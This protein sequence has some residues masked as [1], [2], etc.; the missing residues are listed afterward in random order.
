M[1]VVS[2]CWLSMPSPDL[3]YFAS[4]SASDTPAASTP[5]A[6]RPASPARREA[7]SFFWSFSAVAPSIFLR[8]DVGSGGRASRCRHGKPS[9]S[10]LGDR[11]Q[12]GSH[13]HA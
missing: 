4:K 12:Q 1:S 3:S 10:Y 7:L 6:S 13:P 5:R 9:A 2:S 8:F 11:A